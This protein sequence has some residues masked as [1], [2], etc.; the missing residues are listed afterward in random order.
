MNATTIFR[1]APTG[2]VLRVTVN[3]EK[4]ISHILSFVTSETE[5]FRKWKNS[6]WVPSAAV[7]QPHS[8]NRS[9]HPLVLLMQNS[10]T[11]VQT[12]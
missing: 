8:H 10:G 4:S 6:T 1:T 11:A 5:S 3:Y 2:Q 12:D 9:S 7:S